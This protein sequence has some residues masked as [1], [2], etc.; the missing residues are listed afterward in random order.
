MKYIKTFE[1]NKTELYNLK[2]GDYVIFIDT[3]LNNKI[4][5][6]YLILGRIIKYLFNDTTKEKIGYGVKC[7]DFISN[8]PS[9][10]SLYIHLILGKGHRKTLFANNIIYSTTLFETAI[11]KFEELKET[12][13]YSDWIIEQSAKKYN[14]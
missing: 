14:L 8:T 5:I 4:F 3:V 6:K 11:N 2:I 7:D 10:A 12:Q 9:D 13:P 1:D